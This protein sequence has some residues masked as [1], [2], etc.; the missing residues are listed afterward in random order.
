MTIASFTF[1]SFSLIVVLIYNANPGVGWRKIILLLANL[2][3]LSTFSHDF[4]SFLPLAGFLAAAY[5]S[6]KVTERNPGR[7]VFAGIV[8]GTTIAFFWLKKYTFLP[9]VTF[10]RFTYTTLGLSY[11]FFRAMHLIID[12]QGNAVREK[13]DLISY[14]NYTLNFTTLVS[15][16]IQRY[17]D[18]IKQHVAP[19]RPR[20]TIMDIGYNLERVLIGIFKVNVFGLIFSMIHSQ[21]IAAL[22]PT[23]AIGMRALTGAVI[24]ASYTIYLYYNFSGYTD[25]VIG[26]AGFL[27]ITLPENFNRPFSADNF[28]DFWNRWHMTLSRWLKTYIYNPLVKTLM[29]RFPSTRIEPF[30][31]VAAFFATFFLIGL[32]HGRTSE[33]AFFGLLTGAGVSGNKLFQ[34][35]MSKAMGKKGYKALSERTAY[36]SLCRGLTFTFFT[37]TLLWFWSSWVELGRF[38]SALGLAG[39]LIAW[40]AIFVTSTVAL[41]AWEWIRAA[42]LNISWAGAP[43]VASRYVRTVWD[44]GLVFVGVAVM[45]LMSTPAPDIVYKTF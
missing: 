42:A 16:P 3:F 20:I 6:V 7:N 33:F 9:D 37:F 34:I 10:L 25:I 8:V 41:A 30:L 27:R 18:F 24:A 38:G 29:R 39:Q 21:A 1:L 11:I 14:L 28:L 2:A 15:G 40:L 17:D 22:S 26:I 23:Q 4:V 32:W 43:V 36:K 12:S 31:G 5:L 44:T 13:V 19:E 45:E 35:E